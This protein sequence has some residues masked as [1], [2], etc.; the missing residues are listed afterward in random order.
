[1][2]RRLVS[3]LVLA[4]VLAAACIRLG[5]W[6]LSRLS[7]RKALNAVVMARL[8]EPLAPLTTL[9]ADSSSRLRRASVSGTADFDH[10]VI[11]AARSYQGSPGVYL[12]T[13]VHVAGTDTAV[14][15]NRGWIY[16]PDGV[17]VDLKNWR[18]STTSFSGFVEI[19]PVG[20]SGVPDGVLRRET[21]IA[22]ALD[23]PTVASLLPFPVSP[24]YLVAT[25]PDTTKPIEQRVAR[26]PPPSLDEGPHLSYAIQWFAFATI[27]L[28]CGAIVAVRG[29]TL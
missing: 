2:P 7:Q 28:V 8:A 29:R 14:L 6:Q 20:R 10:E 25:S 3:F 11:L 24:L 4:A 15:V 23:R 12:F 22:R 19:L 18:E 5:F 16:T 26:L 9:R 17:N 13:P 27:A 1:M 21:R